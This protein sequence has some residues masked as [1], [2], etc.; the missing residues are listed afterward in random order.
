LI[1]G[2]LQQRGTG[3]PGFAPP[4]SRMAKSELAKMSVT[5]SIEK[6][7][8]QAAVSTNEYMRQAVEYIDKE[9]GEGYAAEHPDLV[10]AFIRTCAQDCHTTVLV[11]ALQETGSRIS[12][13]LSNIALAPG[14][15]SF[16]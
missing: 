11:K 15:R 7:S 9:F 13:Q 12:S 2:N 16:D 8:S 10:G 3:K 6:L 4:F 1:D 5:T 14:R